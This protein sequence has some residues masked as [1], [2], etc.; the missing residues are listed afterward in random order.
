MNFYETYYY[1]LHNMRITTLNEQL[2]WCSM[3]KDLRGEWVPIST[4]AEKARMVSFNDQRIKLLEH[5]CPGTSLEII[6]DDI[7]RLD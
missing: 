7:T 1:N 5:T 6:R 4:H 3:V 2:T